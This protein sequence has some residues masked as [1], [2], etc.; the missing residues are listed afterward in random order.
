[1][2]ECKDCK[3][4]PPC[5]AQDSIYCCAR[6]CLSQQPDFKNQPEWLREVVEVEHGHKILFFPKFHC[7]LNFI[8]MVWGYIK[9][10]LRQECTFSLD[11]LKERVPIVLDTLI[12]IHF[13]RKA[14][15]HCLIR[16]MAGYREGLKGPNI[17]LRY[18]DISKGHRMIPSEEVELI[19][20]E[21]WT[22]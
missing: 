2:L 19:K 14:A 3:E 15:R 17:G 16:F 7:E 20:E 6:R 9:R 21:L 18:E 10:K 22:G 4:G 1:M 5:T 13:V 12:P 8:E 11:V